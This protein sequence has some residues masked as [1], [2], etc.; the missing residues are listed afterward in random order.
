MP[1]EMR[2]EAWLRKYTLGSRTPSAEGYARWEG[3]HAATPWYPSNVQPQVGWVHEHVVQRER[4]QTR[5]QP[6]SSTKNGWKHGTMYHQ[7][8]RSVAKRKT[9]VFVVAVVEVVVV[10]V[11]L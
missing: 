1:G 8:V 3:V 2:Q 6:I 7:L 4:L 11:E 10:G 9:R 5:N